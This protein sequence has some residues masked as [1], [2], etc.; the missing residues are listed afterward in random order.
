MFREEVRGT[1][2]FIKIYI[3]KIKEK[4]YTSLLLKLLQNRDPLGL[5]VPVN[6]KTRR[7]VY[8]DR[9]NCQMVDIQFQTQTPYYYQNYK[10]F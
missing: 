3:V 2:W 5:F 8:L 10:L 9:W 4:I 1:P 7:D 6:Q